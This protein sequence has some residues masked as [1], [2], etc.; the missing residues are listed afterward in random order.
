MEHAAANSTANTRTITI[1]T[2]IGIMKRQWM[3]RRSLPKPSDSR[4][5]DSRI[6]AGG[7]YDKIVFGVP[8]DVKKAPLSL[9]C[10]ALA[11][12]PSLL[13]D[14]LEKIQEGRQNFRS[15]FRARVRKSSVSFAARWLSRVYLHHLPTLSSRLTFHD[16]LQDEFGSR[17]LQVIDVAVNQNA[18]LLV[19][20][21]SKDMHV[22]F[23]VGWTT[24]DQMQ[25][26]MGFTDGRFVVPQLVLIDR[27][28]MIHYQT[29][30]FRTTARGRS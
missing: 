9:A 10:V 26:F 5:E 30:R 16:K 17:G 27:Q 22:S 11:A 29:P 15:L 4:R 28:G 2:M 6:R 18:D 19:E 13:G 20:N 8:T 21:F 3:R 1:T 24:Q 12:V 7:G 23:P 25:N 14:A